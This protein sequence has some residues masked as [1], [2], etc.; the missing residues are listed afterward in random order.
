MFDLKQIRC[1]VAVADELHFCR[2]AIS[3]NMTQPPLTRQIKL[4]EKALDVR[5]LDRTSRSVKLTSAGR[6]FLVESRHILDLAE[7]AAYR[8]RQIGEGNSGPVRFTFTP[9]SSNGFLSD[10]VEQLSVAMPDIEI[11]LIETTEHDQVENLLAR[12]SDVAL[13]WPIVAH[14]DLSSVFVSGEELLVAVPAGLRLA[15]RDRISVEDLSTCPFIMYSPKQTRY[16]HDLVNSIFATASVVPRFKQQV[17]QLHLM[18]SLV[19]SGFGCAIVPESMRR[20]QYE[21][22]ELRPLNVDRPKIA[23]THL[24]WRSDN[25]NVLVKRLRDYIDNPRITLHRSLGEA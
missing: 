23:Q 25:Q 17:G 1:F 18:M 9:T 20:I 21:N 13:T 11:H 5:L 22:V 4:L 7:T 10:L 24:V 2:A 12:K 8:V 16:L 15:D 6:S 3:L 19:G 14:A